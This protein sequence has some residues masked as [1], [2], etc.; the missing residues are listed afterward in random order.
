[1]A[2]SSAASTSSNKQNGTVLTFKIANRSEIAVNVFSP[3]DRSE[4]VVNFFPGGDAIISTP[5]V[6]KSDGSVYFKSACPP[7]N[8]SL[9]TC[10]NSWLTFSNV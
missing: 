3:P 6:S 9:I 4:I 5:V 1:M 2:S 8:N 10:W 7:E